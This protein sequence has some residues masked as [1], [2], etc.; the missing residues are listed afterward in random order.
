[1]QKKQLYISNFMPTVT[2]VGVDSILHSCTR[3]IGTPFTTGVPP[4]T[5]NV[6]FI[7]FTSFLLNLNI[8]KTPFIERFKTYLY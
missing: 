8:I 4:L 3:L 1:M 2:A 6:F 7:R 5:E